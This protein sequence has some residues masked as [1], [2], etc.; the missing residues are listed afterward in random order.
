MKNLFYLLMVIL[1]LSFLP[2]R[3]EGQT[4]SRSVV[5]LKNGSI[6]RGTIIEMIPD[7][8]IKIQT[9]DKNVFVYKYREIEKISSEQI[10]SVLAVTYAVSTV[11]GF[12]PPPAG[13][14]VIYFVSLNRMCGPYNFFHNDQYIGGMDKKNYI[15]YECD[16]GDQ[17]F[18]SSSFI[19][20][21]LP[22]SLKEGAIYIVIIDAAKGIQNPKSRLTPISADNKLFESAAILIKEK[23]PYQLSEEKFEKKRNSLKDFIADMLNRY[24]T[25][26]KTTK[27]YQ[28]ISPELAI[29]QEFIK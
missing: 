19:K 16:P 15:R 13:K 3:S 5:Y 28:Y 1:T 10:K 14:S 27:Q 9:G 23:E 4:N 25:D 17:L 20:D 11:P 7:S 6:I 26:W 24:E 12:P 21:F 22:A 29:P 18:W 2:M 8:L